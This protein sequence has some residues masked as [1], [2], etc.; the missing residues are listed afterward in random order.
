MNADGGNVRRLT[1]Q[2][3]NDF[4]PALSPDGSRVAF[5]S[6]RDGNAEI[7]LVNVDGTGE[8]RL[9]YEPGEDR[10][11]SWSPDGR[12][13]AFNSDRGARTWTCM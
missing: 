9:T 13:I 1:Y 12:H 5:V 11:P 4:Y 6:E 3:G 7:Y 2:S 8:T 10:L